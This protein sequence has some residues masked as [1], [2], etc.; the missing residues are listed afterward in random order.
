MSVSFREGKGNKS[1][2]KN[3]KMYISPIKNGIVSHCYAIVYQEGYRFQFITTPQSDEVETV[4]T[5]CAE[6]C[7]DLPP[8]SISDWMTLLHKDI[9]FGVDFLVLFF[10]GGEETSFGIGYIK[11]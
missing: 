10:W 6:L 11:R 9:F 3:G 8:A 2:P 1:H 4:G 7:A 5:L